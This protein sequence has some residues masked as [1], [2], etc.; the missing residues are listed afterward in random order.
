MDNKNYDELGLIVQNDKILVSSRKVAEVYGK[1]HADVMRDIRNII[2]LVPETNEC[3]FALV[4][5][6]DKKGEKRPEYLMDRQGFA[7]LVTGFTGKKAKRFTYK[8]TQAFEAMAKE[9][10]R[11]KSHPKLPT[12]YKEALKALLESVE[13]NERLQLE[14]IN[15]QKQIEFLTKSLSEVEARKAIN[16]IIQQYGTSLK[17]KYD[18]AWQIFYRRVYA[19]TNINL[20]MRMNKRNAKNRLDCIDTKE[21]WQQIFDVAKN[22]Y[23][24]QVGTLEDLKQLLGKHLNIKF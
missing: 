18:V 15:L 1:R 5:Y 14:N 6:I 24:E 2:K 8:Y 22:L 9:L 17:G 10:E 21:E 11:V 20:T 7:M 4:D 23:L 3:N 13:E 19:T 16:V 12:T